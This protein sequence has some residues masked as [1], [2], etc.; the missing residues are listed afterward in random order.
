M[1]KLVELEKRMEALE[2]EYK[3]LQKLISEGKTELILKHL[4]DVRPTFVEEVDGTERIGLLIT[5]EGG[6][7]SWLLEPKEC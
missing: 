5:L 6:N 7:I 2:Q 3:R 1:K 4:K